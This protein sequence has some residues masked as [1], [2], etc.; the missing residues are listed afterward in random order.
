VVLTP[1]VVLTGT[2]L[3][4]GHGAGSRYA[5]EGEQVRRVGVLQRR[6]GGQRVDV[7]DGSGVRLRCKIAEVLPGRLVLDVLERVVEPAPAVRLV[8]VQALTM[9]HPDELAIEAATEAGVDDVVP[10]Q[11]RRSVVVWRGQRA[12]TSRAAWLAVV[13]E[14]TERSRRAFVPAIAEPVDTEGLAAYVRTVVSDGGVAF[15]LHA[16]ASA[17][18]D[19]MPLPGSGGTP[20]V[21]LVVGPDGGIAAEEHEALQSAGA[22]PVRLGPHVMSTS[23]A[24]PVAVA[25]LAHRLGRWA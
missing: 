13:R 3:L 14:A 1:P 10:W 4:D 21:V 19:G 22:T 23:T 12:A 20:R 6:R 7:V 25:L 15:V 9:G 24:G 11:A 5:L 8:L 2:G 16:S 17:S 18:L